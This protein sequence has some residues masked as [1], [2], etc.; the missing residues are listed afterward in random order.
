MCVCVYTCQPEA[1]VLFLEPMY[2]NNFHLSRIQSKLESPQCNCVNAHM[3]MYIIYSVHVVQYSIVC[4]CV[5]CEL[6][7]C[8]WSNL[9][10]GITIC[11]YV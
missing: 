10:K 1:T 11:T 8:F 3:H 5:Q 7:Y 6:K 9:V 4:G 2:V